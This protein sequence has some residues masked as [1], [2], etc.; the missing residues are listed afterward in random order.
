VIPLTRAILSALEMSFLIKR[1]TNLH[2]AGYCDRVYRSV[3]CKWVKVS[4]DGVLKVV[5]RQNDIGE[6][7]NVK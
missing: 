6:V 1:Y 7:R 3:T 2:L 5:E 4:G